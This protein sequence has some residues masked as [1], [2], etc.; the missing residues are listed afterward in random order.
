MG[1]LSHTKTYGQGLREKNVMSI[2]LNLGD[3]NTADL[4]SRNSHYFCVNH[5]YKNLFLE[6]KKEGYNSP[7]FLIQIKFRPVF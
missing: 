1:S 7:V 4:S 2:Q 6:K 5:P 3:L